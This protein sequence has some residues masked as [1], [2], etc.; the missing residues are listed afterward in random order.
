M[1]WQKYGKIIKH[2]DAKEQAIL[3]TNIWIIQN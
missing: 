2:M 3:C 1:V